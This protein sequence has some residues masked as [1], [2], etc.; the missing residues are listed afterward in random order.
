MKCEHTL[1]TADAVSVAAVSASIGV[2]LGPE[3]IE[4]FY[5][6]HS[7]VSNRSR[8]TSPSNLVEDSMIPVRRLNHAVFYVRDLARSV[9][10]YEKVFGFEQIDG[11]PG[12]AAFLRSPLADN[13]H[14]IGL[15]QLGP[16]APTRPE[17]SIGLYHLA[18]EVD[19]IT[20]LAAARDILQAEGAL[21]GTSD[22]GVSKSL[23]GRDPDGNEFEIMWAVPPEDWESPKG[24]IQPLDLEAD[25]ARWS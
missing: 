23:Y 3:S 11:L 15:F 22:H 2:P 18:W 5:R 4:L 21:A 24:L 13:H 17:G 20:D 1:D 12:R 10:F 25:L 6:T 16:Q 19:S 9:D 14:D 7:R 8:N